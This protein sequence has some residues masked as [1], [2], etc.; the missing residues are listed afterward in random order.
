MGKLGYGVKVK[1]AGKAL[2]TGKALEH[3]DDT[4]RFRTADGTKKAK[5]FLEKKGRPTL[6]ERAL[7]SH[8]GLAGFAMAAN[9]FP[10]AINDILDSTSTIHTYTLGKDGSPDYT[11]D[12]EVNWA[13]VRDKAVEDISHGLSLLFTPAH[14]FSRHVSDYTGNLFGRINGKIEEGLNKVFGHSKAKE[15]VETQIK[16]A[17]SSTNRAA[18]AMNET[19]N[20]RQAA[21][22]DLKRIGSDLGEIMD[23]GYRKKRAA[24]EQ[25]GAWKDRRAKAK[26]SSKEIQGTS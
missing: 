26:A 16:K 10:D 8:S 20:G 1:R 6:K 7:G 25:H 21:E 3:V 22:Q 17:N 13:S 5:E 18:K 19:I 11:E 2:R 23:P 24:L 14:R 9:A 12:G 15:K 4:G